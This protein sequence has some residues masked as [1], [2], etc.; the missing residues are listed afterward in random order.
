MLITFWHAVIDTGCTCAEGT[1]Q[2]IMDAKMVVAMGGW[3]SAAVWRKNGEAF[4]MLRL[5]SKDTATPLLPNRMWGEKEE[6]FF[7]C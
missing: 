2:Y 7:F 4:F 5:R 3:I 1:K 6:L